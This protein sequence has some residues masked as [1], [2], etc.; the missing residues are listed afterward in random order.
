MG[1]YT[2][3]SLRGAGLKPWGS[4]PRLVAALSS[5]LVRRL[6]DP[7][8]RLGARR[9][10]LLW[11]SLSVALL[12]GSGFKSKL[13]FYR[14]ARGVPFLVRAISCLLDLVLSGT[15]VHRLSL[16]SSSRAGLRKVHAHQARAS[17]ALG[18]HL[19]RGPLKR[20]D[21]L[22]RILRNS[23]PHDPALSWH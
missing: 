16:T 8:T 9:G 22:R 23:S 7:K 15:H 20:G 11:I 1:P 18:A 10:L 13:N 19:L 12:S 4:L 2:P 5:A 6:E 17:S 14:C 21:K 3:R